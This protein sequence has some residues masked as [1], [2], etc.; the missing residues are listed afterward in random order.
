[1]PQELRGHC[2]IMINKTHSFLTG[3]K[4]VVGT[5]TVISSSAWTFN[6]ENGHW[7]QLPNMTIPR[8]RRYCITFG[9]RRLMVLR[10]RNPTGNN[11]L[12]RHEIYLTI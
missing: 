3:G 9:Y 2:A 7:H 8:D 10:G 6:L 4:S 12:V 5:R 1:M 11:E